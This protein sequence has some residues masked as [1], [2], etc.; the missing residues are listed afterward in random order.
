MKTI[1][2]KVDPKYMECAT[3]V[4]EH[5]AHGSVLPSY[6]VAAVLVYLVYTLKNKQTDIN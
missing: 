6:I 1:F 4:C 5:A 3:G 2:D